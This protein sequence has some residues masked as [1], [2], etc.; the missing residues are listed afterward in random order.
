MAPELEL[1]AQGL[2]RQQH[3]CHSTTGDESAKVEGS[4]QR[5]AAS[6]YRSEREPRRMFA[7]NATGCSKDSELESV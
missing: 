6:A 5:R 1:L 4:D 2:E 7:V 3:A